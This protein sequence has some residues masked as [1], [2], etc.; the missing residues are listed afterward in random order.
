MATAMAVTNSTGEHFFGATLG[1]GCTEM[2][3]FR[4]KT[5]RFEEVP[6][7]AIE[8]ATLGWLRDNHDKMSMLAARAEADGIDPGTAVTYRAGYPGTRTVFD[9]CISNVGTYR[10]IGEEVYVQRIPHQS[11]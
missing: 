11:S 6:P 9:I 1:G 2:A 4:R 10:S 7:V 3:E 8:C 5:G